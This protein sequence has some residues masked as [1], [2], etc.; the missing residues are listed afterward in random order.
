MRIA[1]LGAGAVGG[2][3]GARLAA[4]G[5]DVAFI[6]RGAHLAAL[7][8][9]GLTVQ[10]ANGDVHVRPV[11]ATDDPAQVGP[12]DLVLFAVKLWDTEASA[13]AARPMMGPE[14]AI[15][16]F[17]N[18]VESIDTLGRVLGPQR[19]IGGSAFIAAVVAEP[20]VVRHT[21]TLARLVF[22]EP[23]GRRSG[24]VAALLG[25]C[26]R[27]GIDGEASDRIVP[28]IWDKFIFLAALSG[29]TTLTRQPIGPIRGN[30]SSR[31]LFVDAM[32]EVAALGRALGVAVRA[33]IVDRHAALL[34]TLPADM[35]ASMLHDLDRGRRLEL[36]WLSGAVVRLGD[37]HGVPT[38]THRLIAAALAPFQDGAPTPPAP[39]A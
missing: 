26:R 19:V 20:G 4:A 2:Y 34:D 32:A 30:P 6:A 1:V 25:A 21:G 24:R 17:Q 5:E 31:A 15:A 27:A 3:F 36:P 37:H 29:V 39:S 38:P 33:D 8:R 7:R 22:G 14:T 18:G 13:A 12:V 9:D 11:T 10:S 35:Q 23:D 28:A 16:T